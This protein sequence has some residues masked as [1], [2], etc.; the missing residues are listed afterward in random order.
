MF[1]SYVDDGEARRRSDRL[2][3][4]AVHSESPPVRRRA[5]RPTYCCATDIG[6]VV[7]RS[8]LELTA[9]WIFLRERTPSYCVRIQW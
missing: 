2:R 9:G 4:S 7:G 1:V 5:P 6:R 3:G 8:V